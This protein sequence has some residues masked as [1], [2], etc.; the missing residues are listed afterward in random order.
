MDKSRVNRTSKRESAIFS[1][2]SADGRDLADEHTPLDI[3]LANLVCASGLPGAGELDVDS[4]LA[5]L[6]E[7]AAQ[8]RLATDRNY[9]KFI[10]NPSEFDFSQARFCMVCLVS[11]LQT[12]CRVRYHPKW[13]GLKVDDEIPGSFG[14]DASDLFIHSIIE[15]VGGTCGSLPVLYAAVGRRLGYPLKIVKAVRHLFVRWDD[16]DGA[17][18]LH[19]ERFN[20]EATGPGIHFLPDE[21]YRSWPHEIADEDVKSGVFLQSLTPSEERAEFLA[22]RGY[23]LQLNGDIC[24]AIEALAHASRLTPRASQ[25]ALCAVVQIVAAL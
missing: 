23:C 1:A 4:Y 15:G 9:H 19:P 14:V 13:K 8:V 5:W 21:H 3:A 10:D 25:S 20:V 7:A 22:A 24:A 12:Q 11:V 17:E 2:W 6:D 18:W 16:A